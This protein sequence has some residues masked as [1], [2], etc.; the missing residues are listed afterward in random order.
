M[1]FKDSIRQIAGRID[2]LKSNLH[3]EEATKT[4][5][6]LPFISALGYD[7][8]NPLEVL[9]EM[10]CDLIKKKGEKLDYAIIINGTPAILIECKHIDEDL[11]LHQTQLE[12][13]FVASPETKFGVLTNGIIY[14][15]YT[16]LDRE[17]VMDKKPFLE[18]DMRNLK[19]A[20]IDEL[21]KFHKSYFD[22]DAILSTA[23]ELKYL[24]EIKAIIAREAESPSEGFVRFLG[25]QVYDGPFVAKVQEQF[26]AITKRAFGSY[27]NDI[28]AER[29]NAAI[30]ADA[31]DDEQQPQ[32]QTEAEDDADS[33]IVT[34]E[35]EM[36]AFYIVKSILREVIHGDR[37]CWKDRVDYF[38]V[39]LDGMIKK[40]LICRFRFNSP[41][42]KQLCLYDDAGKE[43]RYKIE[44]IDEIYLYS[45]QL[46]QIAGR[47]V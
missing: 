21:K 10:D 1:D 46:K 24:S 40:K 17:N 12:K 6:V 42:N 32:S 34:T 14:R 2:A 45:K 33:R 31:P 15:F 37:V 19:D 28:I 3:T 38:S 41:S 23:S 13:Y 30:K 36:E 39:F 9:P 7:V 20:Q 16:D 18:V 29:L 43:T 27:I 8:F 22:V 44:I 11:Q 35:E 4:A 5:L 26:T 25:K 47:F